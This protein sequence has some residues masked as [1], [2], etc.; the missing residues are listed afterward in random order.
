MLL[1]KWIWIKRRLWSLIASIGKFF[2]GK[3]W[4]DE[5]N[6][7]KTSKQHFAA[8]QSNYTW[9]FISAKIISPVTFFITFSG[10]PIS[11]TYSLFSTPL[12][13]FRR[14][15]SFNKQKIT[16]RNKRTKEKTTYYLTFN[17]TYVR[18]FPDPPQTPQDFLPCPLQ[19]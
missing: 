6:L 1:F 8:E 4:N 18:F 10:M 17:L 13:K 12:Q 15:I 19:W 5:T 7:K 2:T 3:T 14:L 16:I 9:A 11:C